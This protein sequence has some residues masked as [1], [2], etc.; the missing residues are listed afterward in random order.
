MVFR[1][2]NRLVL[3]AGEREQDLKKIKA[4][5]KEEGYRM[6]STSSVQDIVELVNDDRPDLIILSDKIPGSDP[7]MLCE[8]LKGH[9]SYIKIPVI[10]LVAFNGLAD[11]LACIE[12]GADE[13]LAKPVDIHELKASIMRSMKLTT[14][15]ES[16]V[17]VE[18]VIQ[19][20]GVA[21]ESKDHFTRGHSIR[22]ADHSIQLAKTIGVSEENIEIL[23]RAAMLHDI[24]QIAIEENVLHKPDKLTPDEFEHVKQHPVIAVK[25]LE[26]LHLPN[27]LLEIIKH[28]HEWWNGHGYP[29][30]LAR[31]NIPLGARIV[32]IVDA[33]DAMTSD[34]P[35]RVKMGTS[36]ALNRLEDGANRQWDPDLIRAFLGFERGLLEKKPAEIRVADLW[37][38][39]KLR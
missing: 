14:L 8:T 10:M 20:L 19:S 11:K 28:H 33:F 34:R 4:Y 5:L 9:P 18:N 37:A 39:Y 6:V 30:G 13:V 15:H 17:S 1:A 24:G 2:E 21:I 23:Y 38:D 31:R 12:A 36:M 16:L 35:Y 7:T 25:I 29:D 27:E 3:I 26:P 32:S 22:V